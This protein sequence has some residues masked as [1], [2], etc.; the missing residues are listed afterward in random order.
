MQNLTSLMSQHTVMMAKTSL[1]RKCY[2][3]FADSVEAAARSL[4]K[5]T[6][7]SVEELLE[8]I[9]NDRLEDGNLMNALLP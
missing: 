7:H 2:Y 6:Q 5:V 9:F 8:N 3:I 4:P 1:Q